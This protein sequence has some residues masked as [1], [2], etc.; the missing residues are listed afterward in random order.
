SS[1]GTEANGFSGGDVAGPVGARNL[2]ISADGR[3][4][5]FAS[6]ATNLVAGAA[7]PSTYV[8]DNLVGTTEF[9][10]NGNAPPISRDGRFVA[11]DSV[12]GV[13]ERFLLHDRVTG[14][15]T[16][17][18]VASGGAHANGLSCL[19]GD[20]V[21]ADGRFIAFESQASNLVPEDTNSVGDIFV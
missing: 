18:S 9:I 8:H 6:T 4:V 3:Y 2:S 13:C 11:L 16:V 12:P 21:S 1:T 19:V 17:E 15:T 14:R 5:A 20:A 7:P 10:G